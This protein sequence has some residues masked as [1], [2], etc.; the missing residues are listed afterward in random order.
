MQ[1]GRR[2]DLYYHAERLGATF[3]PCHDALRRDI[4]PDALRRGLVTALE[5]V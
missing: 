1:R 3:N 4:R 5:P 2:I